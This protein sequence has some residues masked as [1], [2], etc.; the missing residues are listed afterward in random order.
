[1]GLINPELSP[2]S[3]MP[4][5]ATHNADSFI[6]RVAEL[7]VFSFLI[8]KFWMT[9]A[10]AKNYSPSLGRVLDMIEAAV[11][12]W[13]ETMKPVWNIECVKEKVAVANDYACSGLNYVQKTLPPVNMTPEQLRTAPGEYYEGSM[14]QK[15]VETARTLPEYSR[16][17][18]D[19]ANESVHSGLD[20]TNSL[21]KHYLASPLRGIF[22]KVI[23]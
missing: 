20:Y 6:W 5:T 11:G 4:E 10:D 8:H 12:I 23:S 16:N 1:V 3:N 21:V 17:Q 19:A 18:Y 22:G 15:G 2:E 7:P 14:A 13:V 9:Y